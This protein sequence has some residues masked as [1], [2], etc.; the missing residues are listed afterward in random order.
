MILD[1]SERGTGD[2][3]AFGRSSLPWFIFGDHGLYR[4]TFFGEGGVEA[5]LLS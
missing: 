3:D 2:L 4:V 1:F 5:G